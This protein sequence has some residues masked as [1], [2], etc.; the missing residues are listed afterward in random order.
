MGMERSVTKHKYCP[1]IPTFCRF[2]VGNYLYLAALGIRFIYFKSYFK[3]EK[4]LN[5]FVKYYLV[6]REYIKSDRIWHHRGAISW[7]TLQF[8]KIRKSFISY[9]KIETE[10]NLSLK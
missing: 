4:K 1:F 3:I 8:M 2:P 5:N 7:I 6:F 9:E 10:D